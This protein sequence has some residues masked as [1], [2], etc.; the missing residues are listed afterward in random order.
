MSPVWDL[1]VLLKTLEP[2]RNPG[3]FVFGTVKLLE[4]GR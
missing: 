1:C 4:M 3:V 2:V